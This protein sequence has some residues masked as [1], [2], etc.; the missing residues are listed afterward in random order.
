MPKRSPPPFVA[1][2]FKRVRRTS[3]SGM[4]MSATKPIAPLLVKAPKNSGV[5]PRPSGAARTGRRRPRRVVSSVLKN[6]ARLLP[7][8]LLLK[9]VA[10]LASGIKG[11]RQVQL[12][13][14]GAE[15][16]VCLSGCSEDIDGQRG[17]TIE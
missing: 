11:W 7:M 4:C 1:T 12:G 15:I 3:A 8:R 17:L 5:E 6:I 9:G 13:L 16:A 14:L 10:H 2:Y